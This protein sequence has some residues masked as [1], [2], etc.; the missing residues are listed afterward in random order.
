[1]NSLSMYKRMFKNKIVLKYLAVGA[2]NTS[3]FLKK[4]DGNLKGYQL[5][6]HT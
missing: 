4:K 3:Q 2:T 1:M 6:I 5:Q